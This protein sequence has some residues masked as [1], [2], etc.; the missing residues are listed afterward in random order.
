MLW[1]FWKPDENARHEPI[2]VTKVK[3]YVE[4]ETDDSMVE[5]V[6]FLA[7]TVAVRDRQVLNG[8]QCQ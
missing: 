7:L 3:D 5:N 1:R 2:S 8:G 6:W 4:C